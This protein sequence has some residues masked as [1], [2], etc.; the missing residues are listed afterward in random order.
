MPRTP[1]RPEAMEALDSREVAATEGSVSPPRSLSRCKP[2]MLPFGANTVS[3]GLGALGAEANPKQ[4]VLEH[5]LPLLGPSTH[6]GFCS[7]S[8]ICF[9]LLKLPRM[10]QMLFPWQPPL[11]RLPTLEKPV[12][13]LIFLEVSVHQRAV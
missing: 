8:L 12:F 10:G 6:V 7:V 1:S 5:S 9:L 2:P 4:F 11:L 3:A 13:S